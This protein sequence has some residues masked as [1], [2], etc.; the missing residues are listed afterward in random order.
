[1]KT[2]SKKSET[3]YW[4]YIVIVEAKKILLADLDKVE[5]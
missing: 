2:N 3:S 1:M 5:K 4:C